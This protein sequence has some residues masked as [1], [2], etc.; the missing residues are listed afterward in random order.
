MAVLTTARAVLKDAATRKQIHIIQQHLQGLAKDFKRFEDRMNNL[1][2]HIAQ[3][4][5]D[6]E[7]VQTSANKITSRFNKI[8]QV[9][10]GLIES[11]IN[12]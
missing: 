2:K 8:D 3:A 6:V 4:H 11:E 1:S 9:D 7:E 5:K 10:L 12:T